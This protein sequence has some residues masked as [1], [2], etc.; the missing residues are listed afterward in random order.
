MVGEFLRVADLGVPRIWEGGRRARE[1]A[2]SN[3]PRSRKEARRV[4]KK[5]EGLEKETKEEP[6]EVG[7]DEEW[8]INKV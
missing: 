1:P 5:N 3:N 6:V 2:P 4:D 8:A 7:D